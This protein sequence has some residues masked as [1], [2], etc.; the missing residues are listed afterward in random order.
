MTLAPGLG[1]MVVSFCGDAWAKEL[2]TGQIVKINESSY[3]MFEK[4]RRTKSRGNLGA[5]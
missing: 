1:K 2:S 4:S 3:P 5:T